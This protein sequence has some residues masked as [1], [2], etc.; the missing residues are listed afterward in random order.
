MATN[1]PPREL[2]DSAAPTRLYF[3]N[4]GVAPI[5]FLGVEVDAAVSFFKARGFDTDAANTSAITILKQAKAEGAPVFKILDTLKG[6]DETEISSLIAQI[7]N[8]N[9]TPTST[10]GY[11]QE[12][13][14][15][16][17]TRNIAP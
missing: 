10:L 6:F 17:K 14:D 16:Y 1:L 13:G 12:V 7:L 8:G 5:E 3:D 9:R 2:T 11:K 15:I 4:Y